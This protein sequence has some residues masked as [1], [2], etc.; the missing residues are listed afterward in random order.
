MPK[1]GCAMAIPIRKLYCLQDSHQK[2]RQNNA[3]NITVIIWT[4]E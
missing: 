3:G 1:I 2:T 4:L